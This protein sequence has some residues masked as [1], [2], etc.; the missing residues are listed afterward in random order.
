MTGKP[1]DIKI[2]DYFPGAL[3]A[4]CAM[5]ARYYVREWGFGDVFEPMIAGEMATFLARFD[6]A[7][8]LFKV[9]RRAGAVLGTVTVDGATGRAEGVARLRWFF[10]ADGARGMGLGKQLIDLAMD[11]MRERGFAH[12]AL[13]TFEGLDAARR[14]YEGAGFRL[15]HTALGTSWGAPVTEQKFACDLR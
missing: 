1:G 3:G 12:A 6:P 14:L 7:W 13:W 8:D 11:H 2:V 15:E 4:V 10:V 5:Q 9:A